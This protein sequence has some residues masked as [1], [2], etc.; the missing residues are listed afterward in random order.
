[1]AY[2]FPARHALAQY[3]A[4]GCLNHTYYTSAQQQFD[5]LIGI[6]SQC[7]STF[8]AKVAVWARE[9]GFMKDMPA[10]LAVALAC[11]GEEGLGLLTKIF[12]RVIDNPKMVRNFCQILRSGVMG[13]KSFGYRPRKL[14]NQWLAERTSMELFNATVGNDP[15]LADILKMTH[16]RPRTEEESNMYRYILGRDDYKPALL[17]ET[18]QLYEEF[19]RARNVGW[20]FDGPLPRVP[21][22][23]LTALDLTKEDW[24]EIARN[25]TWTQTRM[26][27]ATFKRHGVLDDA[28]MVALIAERLRDEEAMQKARVFPYQILTTYIMVG[29]E[30]PDAIKFALKAAM[31]KAIENVPT[32]EGKSVIICPDVSGSMGTAVTGIRKGSTT[33][34]RCVD[35]AAL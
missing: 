18:V 12:P 25:A 2:T 26:N 4:T 17:P 6:I 33:A 20:S 16:P 19:K 23:K 21:F 7:D 14:I 8:I 35:V 32:F 10:L 34:T 9:A 15:T 22:Q 30:M 31:D 11:R 28:D 29:K 3:A 27:L 13:R 24:V 1:M 5:E